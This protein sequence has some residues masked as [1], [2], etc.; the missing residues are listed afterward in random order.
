VHAGD[1]KTSDALRP[2]AQKLAE[3]YLGERDKGIVITRTAKGQEMLDALEYAEV[4]ARNASI[5]YQRLGDDDKKLEYQQEAAKLGLMRIVEEAEI[6]KQ[7]RLLVE[8]CK[9]V[10]EYYK[11]AD[12]ENQKIMDLV[13]AARKKCST[14]LREALID[15]MPH[16]FLI[17]HPELRWWVE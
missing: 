4:A 14:E 16:D 3:Q 12:R 10:A 15:A 1:K 6:K 17:R 7:R 13:S 9:N 8:E 5:V 11:K 2:Q